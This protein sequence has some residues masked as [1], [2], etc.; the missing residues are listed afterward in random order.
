MR[1]WAGVGAGLEGRV[2][3]QL[4]SCYWA[5]LVMCVMCCVS[6]P[7]TLNTGH[8]THAAQQGLRLATRHRQALADYALHT[9]TLCAVALAC[10]NEILLLL[11]ILP[12]PNE[13]CQSF[14]LNCAICQKLEIKPQQPTYN[15][16][17]QLLISYFIVCSQHLSIA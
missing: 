4:I 17:I 14:I 3:A 1:S 12:T 8:C 10:R 13:M 9:C 6:I 5:G 11:G 16:N 7:R 2:E 15:L